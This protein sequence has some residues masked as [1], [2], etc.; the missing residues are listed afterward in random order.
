MNSEERITRLETVVDKMADN[1]ARLDEA[2]LSLA[3]SEIRTNQRIDQVAKEL[4]ESGKRTDERIQQLVSAIG[5]LIQ[6]LPAQ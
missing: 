2:M 1:M 6:R 3:E 4:S 5:A